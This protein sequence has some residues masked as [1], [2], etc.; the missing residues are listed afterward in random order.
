MTK[1]RIA[2]RS[3][4]ARLALLLLLV[5]PVACQ[6]ADRQG[7][8]MAEETATGGAD[9]SQAIA[10][11]A[12]D[13]ERHYNLGHA[14]Q[15]AALYVDSAVALFAD[16]TVA[17][18]RAE[19]Q[20]YTAAQMAEGSPQVSIDVIA[21]RSAGDTA[22]AI[23]SWSVTSTPEGGEPMEV[24]GHWMGAYRNGTDG[25]KAL[26][27]ITNYDAEQPP[28][29]YGGAVPPEAP[30]ENSRLGGLIEAY[31][32]AWNAGDVAQVANLYATDAWAAFAN[33]HPREGREAIRQLL[34]TRV[35]G[36]IEIHGVRTVALGTGWS[37]DGGWYRITGGGPTV[38]GNYWLVAHATD[39]GPPRIQW[40]VTNGRVA[41]GAAAD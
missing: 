18:S 35:R 6:P 8:G 21:A 34:E 38:Q 1:F 24:S 39:D 11:L 13:Y 29:A 30:P 3:H 31:T 28:A 23:G 33:N 25:W 32:S 16:G 41:D 10:S 5:L 15:V 27:L 17:R 9:V 20:R 14:D 2:R 37:V 19:I 22:V 26:G 40:T 12:A 36:T 4:L 7:D